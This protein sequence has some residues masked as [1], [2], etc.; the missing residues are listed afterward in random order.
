MKLH[1]LFNL[2][3]YVYVY[4]LRDSRPFFI[5]VLVFPG[6]TRNFLY[7][8][9]S[10][11]VS[12]WCCKMMQSTRDRYR[13]PAL[14]VGSFRICTR[15]D[16]TKRNRTMSFVAVASL[17]S[18]FTRGL[19]RLLRT[20][21][22]QKKVLVWWPLWTP[23]FID[24]AM[25]SFTWRLLLDWFRHPQLPRMHVLDDGF[26]KAKYTQRRWLMMVRIKSVQ[27]RNLQRHKLGWYRQSF[28]QSQVDLRRLSIAWFP[29]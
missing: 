24:I 26:K 4:C 2:C 12:P 16:E 15:R 5:V 7:R 25:A 29:I 14:R 1:G 21:S 17:L 27:L 28:I 19:L 8:G 23:R 3:W 20:Q 9:T 22:Y 13:C 18:R 11:P 10:Q 6:G